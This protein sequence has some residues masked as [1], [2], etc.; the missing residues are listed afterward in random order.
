MSDHY[1]KRA[2]ICDVCEKQVIGQSDACLTKAHCYCDN[3]LR[4]CNVCNKPCCYLCNKDD[5]DY[6]IHEMDVD[7][8][9]HIDCNCAYLACTE[10]YDICPICE[11][12]IK[13]RDI[14]ICSSCIRGTSM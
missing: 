1:L 5:C 2:N 6:G 10:C 9:Q 11:Y 13:R 14:H 7:C 3:C 4:K 12:T 8:K